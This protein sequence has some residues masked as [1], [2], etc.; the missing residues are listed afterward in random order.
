VGAGDEE[1]LDL[2]AAIREAAIERLQVSAPFV[3][4]DRRR[5]TDLDDY[6]R[7]HQLVERR[8]VLVVHCPVEARNQFSDRIV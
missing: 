6:P 5:T 7:R 3:Q 4:P 8:R 1:L 2:V